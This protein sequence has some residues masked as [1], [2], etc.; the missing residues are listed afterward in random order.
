LKLV[1]T[2]VVICALVF[3]IS[4]Q[5][6]SGATVVKLV[7]VQ[8]SQK[9]ITNGFMFKDID[10]IGGK[11]AGHD[12]ATCKLASQQK[13]N[14]SILFY[15]SGGTIRAK[16]VILFSKPSGSGTITGGSG[17]YAGANGKL[18]FRNLNKEGTQTA[19]VLTL[20]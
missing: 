7:A 5:A 19:V 4:A 3:T 1:R 16:L 20:I 11:R 8:Q 14:C 18:T 15:L 10:L 6:A 2:A 17:R 12:T 13:A 9:D